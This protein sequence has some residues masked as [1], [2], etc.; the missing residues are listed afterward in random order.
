MIVLGCGASGLTLAH[1]PVL[2]EHL[3]RFANPQ[4][5]ARLV[6]GMG[7]PRKT[8]SPAAMGA[9]WLW[10][11]AASLEWPHFRVED[12]ERFRADW[13]KEGA[14]AGPLRNEAM[15]DRMAA[16]QREGHVIRWACAH[17]DASLGKGSAGMVG[18]CVDA[19]WRGRALLVA[20]TG[21]H[22]RDLNAEEIQAATSKARRR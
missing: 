7:D 16:L 12:V 10:E 13:K 15:R 19:G 9:D 14:R 2:R 8:D 5:G 11:V 21:E 20:P 18:L 22:L 3:R 4:F 1:L 6:H 17:T